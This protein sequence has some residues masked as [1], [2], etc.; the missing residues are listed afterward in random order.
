MHLGGHLAAADLSVVTSGLI[1]IELAL[2]V[3]ALGLA[4]A[5]WT[6]KRKR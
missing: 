5:L 3:T 1:V 2:V 4:Y 6:P